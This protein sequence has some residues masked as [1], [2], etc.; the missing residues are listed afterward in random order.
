M[1]GHQRD[2][3]HGENERLVDAA[4]TRFVPSLEPA[5]N[6]HGCPRK[7]GE[8]ACETA[9]KACACVRER[10]GPKWRHRPRQQEIP[11]INDE[12]PSDQVPIDGGL[13]MQQ[14][15]DTGRHAENAACQEDREA[16]PVDVAP[17]SY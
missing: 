3:L 1:Y 5:P 8:A 10:A 2:R 11:A 17:K 6:G 13:K 9:E 14:Q 4:L 15:I 16:A 7:P 12:K